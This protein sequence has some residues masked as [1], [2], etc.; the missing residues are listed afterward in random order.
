V[1][2]GLSIAA[3]RELDG[4]GIG[5]D[6]A[7][8]RAL[9]AIDL[10]QIDLV[11]NIQTYAP[12]GANVDVDCPSC[13]VRFFDELPPDDCALTDPC[14]YDAKYFLYETSDLTPPADDAL[15]A[16][17]HYVQVTVETRTIV[18]TLIRILRGPDSS[19]TAAT[20]LAG[21]ES[22]LCNVPA[23]MICNPQEPIEGPGAGFDANEHIGKQIKAKKGGDK[24]GQWNPGEFG[25]LD[26][27][28]GLGKDEVRKQFCVVQPNIPACFSATVDIA[29]GH[30]TGPTMQ[31]LNCRFDDYRAN[32]NSMQYRGN[33]NFA[34][35]KN[36]VKEVELEADGCSEC[37]DD[38]LCPGFPNPVKKLPRDKTFGTNRFGDGDW[39]DEFCCDPDDY[40]PVNHPD[41]PVPPPEL[42]A[43]PTRWQ[44]YRW[45]V[46]NNLI[47]KPPTTNNFE[48]GNA[49]DG[50]SCYAGPATCQDPFDCPDDPNLILDRRELVVAVINCDALGLTGNEDDVP[51]IEWLRVF[52]TEPVPF[53]KDE[54]EPDDKKL[55]MIEVIGALEPGVDEIFHDE[56]VLYR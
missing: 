23:L 43:T 18:N 30:G 38:L 36:V 9:R 46:E 15:S 32:L 28:S 27:V 52:M 55:V 22:F 50:T 54:T 53:A 25:L 13:L 45:E 5:S 7:I 8:A 6:A 20:A 29:P 47:P 49:S 44:V 31:G 24:G 56:I 37:K 17:A 4:V 19:S 40:W 26:A 3:A 34:P 35:A 16:R 11:H 41:N 12:G 1:A 42:G 33:P 51:V 14:V 2:N 21:V 10:A 39:H 48:D